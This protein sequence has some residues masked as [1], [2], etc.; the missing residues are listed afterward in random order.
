MPFLDLAVTRGI[1]RPGARRWIGNGIQL[2]RFEPSRR[3]RAG[4]RVVLT[5]VARLEPVKN[6]DQLLRAAAILHE[7]GACFEL[8]LVG[9]GRLRARYEAQVRALRLAPVVRFLGYRDDI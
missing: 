3:E 9:D 2:S 1:G 6:H 8:W 7:R 4:P 5:C